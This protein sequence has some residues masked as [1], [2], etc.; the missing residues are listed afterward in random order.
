MEYFSLDLE[1]IV[2]RCRE[3]GDIQHV[4]S[5]I[6]DFSPY[7]L[8]LQLP[9]ATS[10]VRASVLSCPLPVAMPPSSP[11][12]HPAAMLPDHPIPSATLYHAPLSRS[13][14]KP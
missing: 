10:L 2:Q 8:R 12:P 14:T 7:D 1:P 13:S 3:R 6:K 11:L 9:R 4:R 5:P